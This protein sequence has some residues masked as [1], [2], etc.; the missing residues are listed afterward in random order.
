VERYVGDGATPERPLI[1]RRGRVHFGHAAIT[2]QLAWCAAAGVER[3]VFTHC[4]SAVVRSVPRT[5][6]DALAAMGR[7]HGVCVELAHD[8]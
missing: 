7:H 5:I 6:D 3:A 4:G 8:G 1:R 2:T